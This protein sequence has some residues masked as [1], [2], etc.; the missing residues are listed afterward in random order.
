MPQSGPGRSR[1]DD[2]QHPRLWPAVFERIAVDDE[3]ADMVS[4]LGGL[5]DGLNPETDDTDRMLLG[6]RERLEQLFDGHLPGISG[7]DFCYPPLS[8]GWDPDSRSGRSG[9]GLKT[10]RRVGVQEAGCLLR[11]APHLQDLPGGR[12][13]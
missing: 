5:A 4:E 7:I 6:I 12:P 11:S 3:K 8:D 10:A 9:E 1:A 2:A 13:R